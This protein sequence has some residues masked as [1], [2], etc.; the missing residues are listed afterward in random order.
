MR[1]L[2]ALLFCCAVAFALATDE[3]LIPDFSAYEQ[4]SVLRS[5]VKEQTNAAW[6]VGDVMAMTEFNNAGSAAQ[7]Y[8]VNEA[9]WESFPDHWGLPPELIV[10]GGWG[11]LPRLKATQ[12]QTLM[13]S[14]RELPLTNAL[15]P[16]DEL[17]I[18]SFHRGT[19]WTTHSYDKR[20]L[21]KPMSQIYDIRRRNWIRNF[22]VR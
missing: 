21:P 15:P 4:T 11:P 6:H 17:L 14:I 16:I 3:S 10:G 8:S 22:T 5:C 12:F 19:N 9:G 2:Q 7:K 20:S 18:V 1:L 13:S